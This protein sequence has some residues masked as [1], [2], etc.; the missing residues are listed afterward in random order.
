MNPGGEAEFAIVGSL[1]ADGKGVEKIASLVAPSDFGDDRIR[2]V[3]EAILDLSGKGESIDPS[4]VAERLTQLG[5][6][7][8]AGGYP[9][10]ADLLDTVSST[11]NLDFHCKAI[12]KARRQREFE[13]AVVKANLNLTAGT[14][15]QLVSD[16]LN[17]ALTEIGDLSGETKPDDDVGIVVQKMDVELVAGVPR[18]IKWPWDAMTNATGRMMWGTMTAVAG[19]SGMGKST[20]LRNLAVGLIFQGVPVVYFAIEERGDE[21]L[22]LMSCTVGGVSYTRYGNGFPLEQREIDAIKEG[23]QRILDTDCLTLNYAKHWSPTKI[24]SRTRLYARQYRAGVV[25]VDHAHLIDYPDHDYNRHVARWAERFHALCQEEGVIGVVAYQPKKPSEGGDIWRPVAL[26]EIRGASEIGNIVEK[27][28]SPFRPWVEVDPYSGVTKKDP[29]GYPR[30]V[31]P[32]AE[33][34]EPAKEHFF[35]NPGKARIGGVQG[36]PIVVQ[37]DPLSGRIYES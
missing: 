37:F 11:L 36:R 17:T 18:G 24:L 12:R 33:N 10:L 20:Y 30:I 1:M 31:K 19:F 29:A 25:I 21:V 35:I 22:G 28:L 4:T 34:G 14:D 8:D 6:L 27:Q 15:P 5:T 2:L 16:D 7:S 23:R 26:D 3:Y 9:F 13:D 32:F